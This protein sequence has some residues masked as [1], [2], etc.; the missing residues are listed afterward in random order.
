VEAMKKLFLLFILFISIVSICS[1]RIFSQTNNSLTLKITDN[2]GVTDSLIFGESSSATNGL[3]VSLGEYEM[4]PVPPSGAFDIRWMVTGYE[5]LKID[6]VGLTGYTSKRNYWNAGFQPGAGGYPVTITWDTAKL[7]NIISG[8][9]NGQFYIYDAGTNGN[10]FYIDMSKTNYVTI[11][12]AAVKSFVVVHV[13]TIPITVQYLQGWNLLSVPLEVKNWKSSD[14]FP[15]AISSAYKY[16]GSYITADSLNRGSGFWVKLSSDQNVSFTGEPFVV[17]TFSLNAGWNMIGSRADSIA[18]SNLNTLPVNLISSF[19]FGFSNGYKITNWIAPGR[20]YWVKT[21]A[22]GKLVNSTQL[23]KNGN[24]VADLSSLNKLIIS[25]ANGNELSL[26]FTSNNFDNSFYEMPPVVADETPDIRFST[27]KF[28]EAF[29]SVSEAKIIELQGLK[30]PLLVKALLKDKAKYSI[31]TGLDVNS[32][33]LS[34][35]PVTISQGSGTLK[36]T[37]TGAAGSAAIPDKY[38]LGQNYPNPFNPT[39]VISYGLPKDGMVTL[40]IYDILGNEVATLVNEQKSA[41]NYSVQFSA[42]SGYSS[43]V[44]FYRI[45]AGSF[46]ETKKLLLLK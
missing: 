2:G 9:W 40:K 21:T 11:T 46:V 45:Q 7:G 25:D 37:L 38:Q 5:G 23:N 36:L 19:Y 34:E 27:G 16:N 29:G 42:G 1:D 31:N 6:Y 44:Y 28:A 17:D 32:I 30:Y 14:L 18:V 22:S 13:F 41:G 33:M 26:Y 4:P 8:R 12:D 3:D 10:K 35:N 24:V 20:G 43:G 39:T 15:Q